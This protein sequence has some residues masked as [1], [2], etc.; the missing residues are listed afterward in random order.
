[1]ALLTGVVYVYMLEEFH[2]LILK[3]KAVN[4]VLGPRDIA[5]FRIFIV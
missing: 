5:P 2:V 1:M 4:D 3:E